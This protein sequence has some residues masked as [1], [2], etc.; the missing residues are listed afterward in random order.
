[1]NHFAVMCRSTAAKPGA[2]ALE[3]RP[4]RR[5]QTVDD[6]DSDVTSQDDAIGF[7]IM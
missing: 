5:V 6:S 1:M 4:P 3:N 2:A 7:L